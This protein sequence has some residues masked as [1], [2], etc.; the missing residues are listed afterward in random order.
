M[1][2]TWHCALAAALLAGAVC[3]CSQKPA[4][5]PG[6][7]RI[8]PTYNPE[9]GR[10]EKITYDRN[11]DGKVD[12]WTFMDGTILVRAELDD[13]YD[14][15]VDRWEHYAPGAGVAPAT[16]APPPGERP[17]GVLTRVE[18]STRHDGKPSRWEFYEGGALTRAEE[19]TDGDGR[20]DKWETWRAGAL[21]IIAL[22]TLGRGRPDRRIIYDTGDEGG[23]RLELD[24]DG[25]GQFRLAPASH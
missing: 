7:D 24:P 13:N 1:A 10:L 4:A 12:A 14:G 5:P 8:K 22:D 18:T 2:R 16:V 19:D 25:T 20:V 6:N 11:G 3:A 17:T 21:A 15:V 23:V 9:T